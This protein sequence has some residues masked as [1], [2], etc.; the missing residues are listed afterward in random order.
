M[1]QYQAGEREQ[2]RDEYQQKLNNLEMMVKEKERKEGTKQRL[3]AQ[4][5][6]IFSELFFSFIFKGGGQCIIDFGYGDNISKVSDR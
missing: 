6:G 3:L 2:E 1:K 4:V 5:C